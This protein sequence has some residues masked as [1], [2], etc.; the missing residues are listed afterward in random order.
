[1]GILDIFNK[2]AKNLDKAK[3]PVCGMNVNLETTKYKSTYKGKVY[4]FCS[5]ECKKTFDKNPF[6][7]ADPNY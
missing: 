3:D 6:Q 7:Y 1:M 5:E 2:A 4:V